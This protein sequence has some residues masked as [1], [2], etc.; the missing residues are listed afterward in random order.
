MK[1]CRIVGAGDFCKSSLKIN[2]NSFLIAADRGYKSLVD[3]GIL[4][5]LLVGDLDSLGFVP[6]FPNILRYPAEKDKTDM[7]LAVA[8]AL[9]KD[10]DLLLLYGALGGRLDHSLSN[11]QLLNYVS[12]QGKKCFIIAEDFVV[13]AITDGEL[14]FSE[15]A[16]GI[17]S[18]FALGEKAEH[19]TLKGL[20][21]PLNDALLTADN[22]LGVSNE[23]SG[24]RASVSVKNGTLTVLWF[25][26]LD[27]CLS[28]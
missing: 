2:D 17:I 24:Q 14:I 19:V 7:Q 9:K 12:K 15:K 11:L 23:F 6:D 27:N 8:Y 13:T 1:A 10:F 25:G 4:P 5:D 28:L 20:K 26:S 18:V 22:P 3:C 16:Q 21:Y